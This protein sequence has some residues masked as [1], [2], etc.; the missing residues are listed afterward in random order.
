[1]YFK[2]L[3]NIRTQTFANKTGPFKNHQGNS[4]GHA[5]LREWIRARAI[6]DFI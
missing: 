2:G 4:S 6:T 1:M 3:Q 5:S